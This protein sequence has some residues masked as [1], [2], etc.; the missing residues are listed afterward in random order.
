MLHKNH[1]QIKQTNG[2]VEEAFQRKNQAL[3]PGSEALS[4]PF[5]N[6]STKEL[7]KKLWLP[8][9]SRTI[10]ADPN[11]W[12]EVSKKLT[13]NSWFTTK[14][15][16]NATFRPKEA[17]EK[18]VKPAEG[19]KSFKLVRVYPSLQQKETLNKWLGVSR[20]TYNTCIA[21]IRKNICTLSKDSLGK[22]IVKQK[23]ISHFKWLSEVPEEIGNAAVDDV[24]QAY[25]DRK[26]FP[27]QF[28]N[29]KY[30][31]QESIL[32]RSRDWAGLFSSANVETLL[33]EQGPK[34]N[35]K[36][37][38]SLF[39]LVRTQNG[40]RPP[41]YYLWVPNKTERPGAKA[42]SETPIP[43]R[44]VISLDPGFRTFMTGYD[45]DGRIWEWGNKDMGRISRLHYCHSDLQ[46]RIDE[47]TNK[48]RRYC[49]RR[50]ASRIVE[51]IRN[52]VYEIHKKL[53]KWLCE[54][55]NVVLIPYFDIK[56]IIPTKKG[57]RKLHQNTIAKMVTWSHFRFRRRLINHSKKY[58]SCQIIVT[59]EAY[60]SKTCGFC[61]EINNNLKS[62]KLFK[63]PSCG[64][65]A[66]RDANA[67]R[68]I[69]LRYLT[70]HP[71]SLDKNIKI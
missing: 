64:F 34:A 27:I 16:T 22:Y 47:E 56:G 26:I 24:L 65:T 29:K 44:S 13:Q 20:W 23:A 19:K 54:L 62:S 33:E 5:W 48:R 71:Q 2:Y 37:P 60:T 41:Y 36:L 3:R 14:K 38:G 53:C 15:F 46:Y 1:S 57:K 4:R 35:V 68:N 21:A 11:S 52:L 10:L 30:M 31:K 49:M 70:L 18:Y 9:K 43:G 7:S 6:S 59:R 66:D 12:N 58:K 28:R 32:I 25:E 55:Y 17:E 8:T 61:G 50:A 42:R 67:A 40:N 51:N 45:L 63:C 69:L 39:C